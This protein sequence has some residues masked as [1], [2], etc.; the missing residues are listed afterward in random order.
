MRTR[1]LA[2]FAA[3]LAAASA[4]AG[5]LGSCD[6]SFGV[7]A[8]IQ[9]ETKQVGTDVFK[10]VPVRAVV[11]D[12]V[13]YYAQG[14]KVHSRAINTAGWTAVA[15]DSLTE[16]FAA[17]LVASG[18]TVYI[19]A[20]D[21]GT[22]AMSGNYGIYSRTDPATA[23][24]KLAAPPIG[25]T[26]KAQSLFHARGTAGT[27][28]LFLQTHDSAGKFF[29]Y[30]WD[31]ASAWTDR[32]PAGG[33]DSAIRN[34]VANAAST[35]FYA[36]SA[37]KV[38]SGAAGAS[39]STDM[40][41]DLVTSGATIGGIVHDGTL[42]IVSGSDGRLHAH[43]G[44][45]HWYIAK[46]ST[47]LGTMIRV[48]I[49]GGTRLLAAVNL[50]TSYFGYIEVDTANITAGTPSSTVA[51]GADGLVTRTE[52]LYS[53]T[54]Y[55][56]PVNAFHYQPTGSAAGTLFASV[57]PGSGYGIYASDWDAAA[58]TWSGWKAQ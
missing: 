42:L 41:L 11:S 19:A 27:G 5:F 4:A 25:G 43:D 36:A 46:P 30:E 18:S 52:S 8:S 32:S 49:S 10:K 48:N 23:W 39:I 53:T 50:P 57:E 15:I 51:D 26:E 54:I 21:R 45:W 38:Y 40:A 31:G 47:P 17:G 6:N 9:M 56:K 55:G 14:V 44:T 34:V 16:Y 58:G 29:L 37:T 33:Y 3:S 22:L 24:T 2:I 13:R 1:A 12:G 20:V 35:M 7:L 28:A